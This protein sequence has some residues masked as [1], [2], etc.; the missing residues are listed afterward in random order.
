MELISFIS[1]CRNPRI[2]SKDGREFMTSCGCCPDCFSRKASKYNVLVNEEAKSSKYLFFVTLT[3][4]YANAPV[5]KL[6][7]YKDSKL[8]KGTDITIR[9]KHP[10]LGKKS[11]LVKSSSYGQV[12]HTIDTSENFDWSVYRQFMKKKE[13]KSKIFKQRNYDYL[14]YLNKEDLQKFL[15][16]LRFHCRKECD[17]S[18]RYFAVG[19][20]SPEHFLPHYHILLFFDSDELSEKC[21]DLVTQ[22][23]E[24]G[25]NDTEPAR[26]F[27]QSASY[28]ASYLNSF[29]KLPRFLNGK[30]IAPFNLHS[31]YLGIQ[32]IKSL[33][34]FIYETQRYSFEPIDYN[35]NGTI[36]K[37]SLSSPIK[38]YFFP[39]CYNYELQSPSSRYFLY[40]AFAR[41]SKDLGTNSI[42]DIIKH[43]YTRKSIYNTFDLFLS[44]LGIKPSDFIGSIVRYG[45]ELEQERSLFITY[46]NRIYTALLTSRR[47]CEHSTYMPD[48]NFYHQE[49]LV[50]IHF[51]DKIDNFY[52]QLEQ[53]KLRNQ[54]LF[55]S[56]YKECFGEDFDLSIFYP[57]NYSE[58][59]YRDIYGNS[60]VINIINIGKDLIYKD[61][62]KHKHINDANEIFL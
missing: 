43:I 56:E 15:K 39:R 62:V 21:K 7:Y 8:I 20:Y 26:D 19:E 24:Y 42:R 51:M 16:R 5:M 55:V 46:F 61:K 44:L 14:Y 3:Y 36:F 38:S 23:W 28:L 47:F 33:L 40:T 27:A 11:K 50:F 59:E 30:Q 34:S 13:K 9:R 32:N 54:L 37:L 25:I 6:N 29:I 48:A 57:L 35:V 1:N 10:R 2:L 12:I 41:Y 22:S 60:S 31:R 49:E 18:F 58:D 45:I 4:N 52:Y 53:Y 17:A